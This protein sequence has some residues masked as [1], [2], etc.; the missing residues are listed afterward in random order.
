[1]YQ[2]VELEK[3]GVA[4]ADIDAGNFTL[5][6]SIYR[7]N[8]DVDDTGRVLVQ[9]LDSAQAVISAAY[10]ST[11]EEITPVDTWTLRSVSAVAVPATTRYIRCTLSHTLVTGIQ[12]DTCFDNID[13]TLRDRV[14]TNAF[15]EVYE[16]RVYKVTTG[17]MTAGSQ[18]TY[19]TTIGNTTT[20]GTA[21]LTAQDSFTRDGH[22]TDVVGNRTIQ[23]DYSDS[24]A[25]DDWFNGGVIVFD[26]G[27]NYGVVLEINDW[28]ETDGV[29]QTFLDFPFAPVPGTPVH[30]Y[31]GCDKRITTCNTLFS[32]AINFRGEPYV[33][34]TDK[35]TERNF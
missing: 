6:F 5:D 22:V 19:D 9:F 35:Q 21:V 4:T 24:R 29:L 8:S 1:M 3:L 11:D 14:G 33:P 34:S 30:V 32:N 16:N 15:Q 13:A 2:D 31:P 23:I 27:E 26:A 18:P 25:V 10:D 12:S 28:T 17:R 20:D 7:A